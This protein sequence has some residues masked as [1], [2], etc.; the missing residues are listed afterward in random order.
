MI[1]IVT[2]GAYCMK[3]LPEK[4]GLFQPEFFAYGKVSGKVMLTRV[5]DFTR[6]FFFQ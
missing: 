4:L 1:W 5:S 6:V 3:L 2:P